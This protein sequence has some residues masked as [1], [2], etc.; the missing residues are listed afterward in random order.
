MAMRNIIPDIHKFSKAK[1]IVAGDVMLDRYFKG[2]VS[3][4]SPEAPVPIIKVNSTEDSLGGA[5]NVALNLRRWGIKPFLFGIL[6]KDNEADVVIN[7][8]KQSGIKNNL[9]VSSSCRTS[10]KLRAVSTQQ[11]LR[12]DFEDDLSVAADKMTELLI[13]K[14]RFADLLILS[15]YNKGSLANVSKI[16]R[17]AKSK[18]IFII[19][20]PK[21]Q[22]FSFYKGADILT[23]NYKEFVNSVG[24]CEDEQT[25]LDKARSMVKQLE[26]KALIITRGS[27]GVLLVMKDRVYNIP[28]KQCEIY[29]VTGAGDTVVATLGA[30]LSAGINIVKATELANL[31][32]GISITNPG[33]GVIGYDNLFPAKYNENP[34][35]PVDELVGT[36]EKE[37]AKGKKIVFTN[38]VFDILHSG[39][40]NYLQEAAQLGD[41]LVVGINDD[42]SVKLNKGQ[43]RP[44]NSLYARAKLLSSLSMV[45]WVVSFKGKTPQLLLHKIKPDFLVKGGDYKNKQEIAGWDIVESY[46]GE[47]K[48]LEYMQGV[49]TTHIIN[50]IK[51]L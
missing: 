13:K 40:I 14:L 36:L 42:K 22:D 26:L 11:L 24:E 29:D 1:I 35:I 43:D 12:M 16:I 49:S 6:G 19:V 30:T 27:A 7:L 20:D 33:T 28:S 3:R 15:D 25:I 34:C 31:A 2:D 23:P 4:V 10:T 46:G 50:K 18:G 45:N 17:A 44:I 5:S 41:K 38:G 32:A 21:L 51:K 47:V 37:R 48:L 8:V 9:L 39:H